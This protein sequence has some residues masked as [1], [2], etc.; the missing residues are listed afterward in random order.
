MDEHSEILKKEI[1]NII[2]FQTEVTQ[3]KNTITELKKT[4][5]IQEQTGWSK[6]RVSEPENKA[7]E[8]IQKEQQEEKEFL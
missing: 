5:G 7:T 6:D 4:R 3:L 8:L 1:K 2:K